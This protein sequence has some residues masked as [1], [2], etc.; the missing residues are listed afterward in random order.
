MPE[1]GFHRDAQRGLNKED[2]AS[3]DDVCWWCSATI[4]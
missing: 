1:I 4:M 3:V 2:K